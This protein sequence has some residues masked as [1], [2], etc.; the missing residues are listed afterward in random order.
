[1]KFWMACIGKILSCCDVYGVSGLAGP[2]QGGARAHADGVRSEAGDIRGGE[3]P[4]SVARALNG[5]ASNSP[6]FRARSTRKP[7]RENSQLI[8]SRS[9]VRTSP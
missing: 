3:Y 2:V 6:G 8:A 9:A 5:S 7:K 1:L 4:V